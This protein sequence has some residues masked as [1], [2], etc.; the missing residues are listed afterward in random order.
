M[1]ITRKTTGL[2][3]QAP[4]QARGWVALQKD[5]SPAAR[6]QVLGLVPQVPEPVQPVRQ[7]DH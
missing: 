2:V 5:R 6:E 4:E 3:L 7:T 1:S